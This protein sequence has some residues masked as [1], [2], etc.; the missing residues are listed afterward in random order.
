MKTPPLLL[1]A[2]LLFWGW[3]SDFL[4]TGAILGAILESSRVVPWR[5]DIED[6]D[7]RR[8]WT[9]CALA[10]LAL[11]A[12]VF[13]TNEEGGGLAGWTH[14]SAVNHASISTLHTTNTIFRWLPMVLF[15]FLIA[16]IFS[17]RGVVPLSAISLLMSWRRRQRGAS[18]A[19]PEIYA[20]VSYSYF[21][22]C[23]F[24]AGIHT[25]NGTQSY[26][27]GAGI[28][29]AWA[30][31]PFRARRFNL[32]AWLVALAMV[33]ALGFFG[34]QG[35]SR[36]QRVLEN[37][38][39]QW[40]SRFIRQK[41]DPTQSVT[42]MGELG[43]LKLSPRIVIR[44]Q[45]E[46]G[47]S[48]VYLR[49][50]SY[51]NYHPLKQA[52][53]AGESRNEFTE[54]SPDAGNETSWTLLAGKTNDSAVQIAC[55]LNG[56]SQELG[57]SEALLPLPSGSGH[58]ENL[59]AASL[60]MNHLGA[61]LAAGN[62]LMIFDAHFGPGKTFDSA[63]NEK[64]RGV[65][66]NLDSEVPAGEIP[67]LD[68]VIAEMNLSPEADDRAKRLAVENFFAQ[69]FSYSTWQGRDKLAGTNGSPL[70]HFLLTSRSGHCEY[71]ATATVL[72]LRHLRI[73]ARYAVGFYVHETSGSGYVVRERDSHSW[74]LAWN[75]EQ[76]TW[77]DMDTTPGSWTAIEGGRATFWERFSDLRSWL[78]FQFAKFRW[79]QVHLRQY[80]FWALIP[81]MIVLLGHIIFRRRTR[82]GAA[83][84]KKETAKPVLWP[85]WD[86]E[87]Y[88]V[89]SK[90]AKATRPRD[91][92][93]SFSDWL[94]S[95]LKA[96]AFQHLAAPLKELLRLHYRLR[97]QPEGLTTKEQAFF[98]DRI[99]DFLKVI[100][101]NKGR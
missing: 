64:I 4:L 26:F 44:L 61:V 80:I 42:S 71:F 100:E 30:L 87:F 65:E 54:I 36:L 81:A 82:R 86:S 62:G 6:S 49:E 29:M 33:V 40:L 75:A 10:G 60:K 17:E 98:R 9:F 7:F 16:Q 51:R 14:G 48:P 72:L 55:Y 27:W 39:A 5:V 89:E 25:N 43:N 15:L 12:Y 77:E 24:A 11:A 28:L 41:S 79:G 52:W 23:L 84:F 83:R 37:Y 68:Q 45:P 99:Q 13:T 58:F 70:T 67:A 95:I 47:S 78:A 35:I 38:N 22:V 66:T 46:S 8:I 31:W 56:W 76:K 53:Y 50:A 2:T 3:Q 21:I 69:H 73:P 90:I 19:I 63:P 96:P 57:A 34:Q 92:A 1:F 88:L 93:E 101:E 74:C 20:D 97:F 85:G 32:S 18:A 94:E 59:P 91:S